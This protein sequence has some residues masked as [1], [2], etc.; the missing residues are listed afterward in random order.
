MDGGDPRM[1]LKSPQI[2]ASQTR[3]IYA[4]QVNALEAIEEQGTAA[5]WLEGEK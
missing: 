4:L 2:L 1:G 5:T 3:L